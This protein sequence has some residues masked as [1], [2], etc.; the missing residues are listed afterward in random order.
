M[1]NFRKLKLLLL[2]TVLTL[3]VSAQTGDIYTIKGHVTDAGGTDLPGVTIQVK[4][5]AQSGTLTDIDGHYSISVKK[6]KF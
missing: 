3:F 1:L 5:N 4:G 6:T 2:F